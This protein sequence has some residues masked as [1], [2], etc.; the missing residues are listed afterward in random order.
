MNY[1]NIAFLTSAETLEQ[2]PADFGREVAFAG[3]SNAGKSS[4]INTLTGRKKLARASKT[5]GRTQ[6]MNFFSLTDSLPP[7][8][9]SAPNDDD[10]PGLPAAR[11]VDL[12]GYGYAKVSQEIQNRWQ[13]N[14]DRYLR[15]RLSLAAIVLIMDIRHPL[16]DFDIAML[17]WASSAGKEILILLTKAD[18]ISRGAGLKTATTVRNTLGKRGVDA[19]VQTFSSTTGAGVEAASAFLNGIFAT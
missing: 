17:D 9:D 7:A 19:E 3:R 2:C 10:E 14:L 8:S 12:P 11:L 15:E 16:K 1:Q 5:P 18:K 4:A 6:L 13:A